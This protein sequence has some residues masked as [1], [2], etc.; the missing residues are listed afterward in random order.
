MKPYCLWLPPLLLL[1]VPCSFS[2]GSRKLP[3]IFFGSYT[4]EK[5]A[6]LD[7]YLI[8]RGYKWLT[9]RLILIASV[10][11][12]I[13]KARSAL[14]LR[15]DME[16]LTWK[17]NVIY[18]DF[19]LGTP[20]LTDHLEDGLF[21]VTIN[22]SA[23]GAVMTE[24]VVRVENREDD[25]TFEYTREGNYLIMRT[26]WKGVSAAGFYRKVCSYETSTYDEK[27]GT[28][29]VKGVFG[30]VNAFTIDD[31]GKFAY[32][33]DPQV[34][35]TI[36]INPST[37]TIGHFVI[38]DGHAIACSP[39][40]ERE[41]LTYPPYFTS[42]RESDSFLPLLYLIKTIRCCI[43]IPE[44]KLTRT[45]S[46]SVILLI[47]LMSMK[48]SCTYDYES[49]QIMITRKSALPC[50]QWE[51][52]F[53]AHQ[54]A[55]SVVVSALLITQLATR[56]INENGGSDEWIM[57]IISSD[58]EK[59]SSTE[60]RLPVF[61]ETSTIM[62]DFLL[63][64]EN[65]MLFCTSTGIEKSRTLDEAVSQE[66]TDSFWIQKMKNSEENADCTTTTISVSLAEDPR[67]VSYVHSIC[68]SC[69]QQMSNIDAIKTLVKAR[70][71]KLS[72]LRCA[73]CRKSCEDN[74][75]NCEHCAIDD[76]RPALF[77]YVT[78][79]PRR[80]ESIWIDKWQCSET[81]EMN[82]FQHLTA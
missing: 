40:R 5:S 27:D 46:D 22:I 76:T 12:V 35:A 50:G 72:G 41:P 2:S 24:N 18:T 34:D 20:F 37:G 28:T 68:F 62:R 82:Q 45:V 71:L 26:T 16:T 52:L 69:V 47:M 44:M 55:A 25:E 4:L 74:L 61:I 11:K 79:Q 65:N 36:R 66:C 29:W 75:W 39:W 1:T 17:K 30:A 9:R 42:Q 64:I 59:C 32:L 21:N 57:R 56:A 77:A 14:P 58:Q 54:V 38:A 60:E 19:T 70:Q 81:L 3:S 10:T 63:Q 33:F 49:H 15:Y 48:M 13:R 73:R 31:D 6:N 51:L 23:D 80:N 53:T 67:T 7:E 8:A 43:V 78:H